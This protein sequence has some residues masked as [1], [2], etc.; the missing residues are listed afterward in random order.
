MPFITEE[1]WQLLEQRSAGESIMVAALPEKH[2]V[3]KKRLAE[4]EIVKEIITQV[5]SIRKDKNLGRNDALELLVRN[6]SNGDYPASFE[7]V[8]IKMGI[9][10][11]I[12]VTVEKVEGAVSFI[13]KNVEYYVPL[14]GLVDAEEEIEKLEK[15][16]EYTRG[17]LTSVMKKLG[18][19]RFVNNAPEKVVEA[20]KKK[21][22]DAA[23]KI[24]TL[25]EQIA[26][27]KE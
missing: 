22:A 20:E 5:R 2:P 19:E 9:L 15:E 4:F 7:P 12:S 14:E 11:G 18:N 8:L 27:L 25:E 24:S 16:L 17:F 6:S 21:Q 26:A 23:T 3:D 13:V 1:L 10:S